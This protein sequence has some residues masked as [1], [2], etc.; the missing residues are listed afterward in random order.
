[1]PEHADG[2][3]Q[4]AEPNS[5][6][7]AQDGVDEVVARDA[8]MPAKEDA[9]NGNG[10]PDDEDRCERRRPP[11]GRDVE[12]LVAKEKAYE[13]EE[14]ILRGTSPANVAFDPP[15][16]CDDRQ[17]SGDAELQPDWR[18]SDEFCDDKKP[19]QRP[20]EPQLE[21]WKRR[22]PKNVDKLPQIVAVL[23]LKVEPKH[24]RER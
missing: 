10:E 6:A 7:D 23:A 19:E 17:R 1:M 8:L 3:K 18:P 14:Q 5:G 11:T 20:D 16:Q 24:E 13:E 4:T 12:Y 9:R 22:R 15:R 21:A 2:R